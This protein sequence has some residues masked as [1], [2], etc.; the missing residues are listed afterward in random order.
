[1]KRNEWKD[2]KQTIINKLA[3]KTPRQNNEIMQK[4]V[5][6]VMSPNGGWND[7]IVATLIGVAHVMFHMQMSIKKTMYV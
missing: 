3:F 4:N 5:G 6:L 2:Y 1:M 7:E